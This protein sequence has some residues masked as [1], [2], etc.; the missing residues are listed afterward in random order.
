MKLLTWKESKY[1]MNSQSHGRFYIVYVHYE[2][3]NDTLVVF[4]GL[5]IKKTL[6][7]QKGECQL[8]KKLFNRL[9]TLCQCLYLH[10]I[11]NNTQQLSFDTQRDSIHKP[12]VVINSCTQGNILRCGQMKA[13]AAPKNILNDVFDLHCVN[14]ERNEGM[15]TQPKKI[16]LLN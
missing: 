1:H 8:N 9:T 2:Q 4:N 12:F 11:S 10:I 5:I 7:L 6:M 14:Q 13:S 15:L 3:K 16:Y